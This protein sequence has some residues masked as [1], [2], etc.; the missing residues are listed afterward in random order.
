MRGRHGW[1][2]EHFTE[3]VVTVGDELMKPETERQPIKNIGRIRNFLAPKFGRLIPRQTLKQDAAQSIL[4]RVFTDEEMLRALVH[5]RPEMVVPVLRLR[6][7]HYDFLEPL[8]RQMLRTPGSALYRQ[9]SGTQVVEKG[10]RYRIEPATGLLDSLLG[11]ATFARD[12]G[13][14]QPIAQEMLAMS[15]SYGAIRRTT[16]ITFRTISASMTR[17]DGTTRSL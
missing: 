4:N 15:R 10:R 13:L 1:D 9:V 8:L 16:H 17:T 3:F 6:E 14:W 2:H 11:D 7:K 5:A 12:H